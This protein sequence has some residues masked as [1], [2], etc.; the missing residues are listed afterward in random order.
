MKRR[1]TRILALLLGVALLPALAARAER[2][3]E[4]SCSVAAGSPIE[5]ETL[6][7]SVELS[8]GNDGEVYV[9]GTVGDDVEELRL[10]CREGEVSIEVELADNVREG[11]KAEIEAHL[12]IA[13]PSGS[14]VTVST[15]SADVTARDLGGVLEVESVS[16][17]VD[18]NANLAQLEIEA[19]S[20][21]VNFAGS[22]ELVEVEAVTGTVT[23][24]GAARSLQVESVSGAVAVE[25]AAGRVEGSTVSGSFEIRGGEIERGSLETVSGTITSSAA[26]VPGGHLSVESHSG[27]VKLSLPAGSGAEVQVT[28]ATGTISNG[29][30]DQQATSSRHGMGK[31]LELTIG[32]GGSRIDV[33]SFSGT[34]E[35]GWQ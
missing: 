26:I 32:G 25:R 11:S 9:S 15:V 23:I 35:L 33:E 4:E 14:P 6:A 21:N 28:S 31:S 18:V 30:S 29:L 8:G 1:K 5:V 17:A 10:E 24:S 16:G 13:V 34:I 3:V 22:S 12:R 20:G 2:S 7:G 19:V 27:V